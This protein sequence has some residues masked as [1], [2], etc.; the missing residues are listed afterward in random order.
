MVAKIKAY[1]STEDIETC[2]RYIDE[3]RKVLEAYG[4]KQVTSASHDWL[5]DENTYVIIVESEDGE[6]IYG[7]GRIQVRNE[8]MKMPMEDAIAKKDER[9]YGYVDNLKEKKIAEFCGL[10]NSKEVAGYGIGSIFLG[11]IGVAITSQIGVEHLFALCSPPTLRQCL[12]IGFEI[13]R[14]LGNNGTFY[15]PKE[16]LI[17]TAIIVNDLANL[18]QAHEEE[19]ERIMHLREHPVQF[20]VEKGPKGEIALHYDLDMKI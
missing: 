12:R 18:P 2:Y 19:R 10:F 6:K 11:R 7:G 15:Y 20:A 8:K 3:H 9:I 5:N 14:D 1:K 17:A 13:I 4:V 16:G